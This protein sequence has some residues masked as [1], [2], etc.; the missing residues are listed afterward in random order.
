[1]VLLAIVT[2]NDMV[3][4]DNL[5]YF[6]HPKFLLLQKHEI[7]TMIIQTIDSLDIQLSANTLAKSFT[8][9]WQIARTII[10]TIFS[11][12]YHNKKMNII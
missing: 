7:K 4:S 1:M 9:R 6:N 2:K 3:I 8:Y 12:C 5:Q 11:I 10:W